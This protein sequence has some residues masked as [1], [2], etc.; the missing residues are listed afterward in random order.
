MAL[1][2]FCLTGADPGACGGTPQQGAAAVAWFG[3]MQTTLVV[4]HLFARGGG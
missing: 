4:S 2:L 3:E 1:S